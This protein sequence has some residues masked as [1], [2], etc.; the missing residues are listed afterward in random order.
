MKDYVAM[1]DAALES[2]L[3]AP[4]E[5]APEPGKTPR[6]LG[7]AMRYSLFAGGKRLRPGMLLAAI[8]ML[9]GNVGEA[10]AIACGLEMIHTYSLIHDDLPCM[11]DAPMRRGKPSNHI[12]YGEGQAVLSG[13]GLLTHA[14]FIMIKSALDHPENISQH[15]SAIKEIANAA[16]INGMLAGQ[17][18]DLICGSGHEESE[19]TLRYIQINKTAKLFIAAMRAAGHLSNAG[20]E[21]MG[22]LSLFGLKYGLLFQAADDINDAA[23]ETDKLTSVSV[24][25]LEGAKREAL[26]LIADAVRAISPFGDKAEF[27]TKLARETYYSSLQGEKA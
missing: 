20:E 25:G 8:D 18:M 11:D 26:K 3:P 5:S 12:Q 9:G 4:P 21:E 6:I 16:G 7:E 15:V 2:F 17:S 22:D 24:F 13:D 19:D 10:M 27:F 23:G 1:I 14:F